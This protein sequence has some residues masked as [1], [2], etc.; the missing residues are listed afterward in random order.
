MSHHARL[1]PSNTR[2]PLCPGSVREEAQYEDVAG[3]AAIDGTGS[4]LLLEVCLAGG[5]NPSDFGGQIIGANHEDS[6]MGWMV[7]QD[8]IERVQVCLDYIARRVKEIQ[9]QYP[10]ANVSVESESKS[11]PGGMFGRDDWY[12]TCD[13]TITVTEGHRCLFIEVIDY[14]DGRGYVSEKNNSQLIAYLT[15]KMRKYVASGPDLVRPF[16]PQLVGDVRMTIVQPKT[17]PPIRYDD[18]TTPHGVVTAA[19]KLAVAALSTDHPDARLVSG[20][21]CQWCKANPKRGGHCTAATEKSLAT[22]KDLAPTG[23]TEDSALD[24]LTNAN[25][26]ELDSQHLSF[27]ADAKAGLDAAFD[28]VMEEI[29]GRLEKGDSVPGYAM[30][31]GRGTRK[32]VGNE[33]DIVKMLKARRLKNV[34]IYPP[35]LITPA[36]VDKLD[37]LK[38][39]QKERIQKDYVAFVAGKDKLTKVAREEKKSAEEMFADVG[40]CATLPSDNDVTFF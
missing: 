4:H 18:D 38:P 22:V 10:G 5:S 29:Q 20:K 37:C 30:K 8:R 34:D 23:I 6:P 31:P 33:E 25:F 28:K 35:K 15:G 13:V 27:L 12:G 3:D 19:E 17:N 26:A 1:S 7:H 24:L 40:Q 36:Q 16:N 32:W 2:W 9:E 39:A 14:K 21:H 11:N